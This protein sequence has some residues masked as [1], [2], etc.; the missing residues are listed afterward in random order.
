[1]PVQSI[2]I[3]F[4]VRFT[5]AAVLGTVASATSCTDATDENSGISSST[6]VPSVN[7]G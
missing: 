7:V 4:L 2:G 3:I 6:N 1:M 5:H